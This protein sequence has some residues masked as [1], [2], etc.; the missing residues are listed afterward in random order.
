MTSL[1]TA[2][3]TAQRK[4]LD[5]LTIFKAGKNWQASTRWN[6]SNGWLVY[7]DVDPVK[8]ALIALGEFEVVEEISELDLLG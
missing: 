4:G 1:S 6:G 2:I 5:G 3:E 8:A 7:H